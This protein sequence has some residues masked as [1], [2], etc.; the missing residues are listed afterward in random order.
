MEPHL[1]MEPSSV[2]GGIRKESYTK[3]RDKEAG[4]L[5]YTRHFFDALGQ[6]L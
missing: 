1:S 6:Q 2:Y 5:K 4:V 3:R